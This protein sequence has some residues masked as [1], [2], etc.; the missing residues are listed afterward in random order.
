M[1]MAKMGY[2]PE[3]VPPRLAIESSKAAQNPRNGAG[4]NVEPPT[5]TTFF[6]APLPMVQILQSNLKPCAVG[7]A[8]ISP[9]EAPRGSRAKGGQL[10][11]GDGDAVEVELTAQGSPS[12]PV[13]RGQHFTGSGGRGAGGAN[14]NLPPPTKK[15]DES[16][17]LGLM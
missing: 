14:L 8:G 5:T 12:G 7:H 15:M 4:E 10:R 13:L 9:G 11:G 3:T 17:V 16:M 6:A 1:G 2:P